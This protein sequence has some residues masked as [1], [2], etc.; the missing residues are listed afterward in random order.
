MTIHIWFFNLQYELN[1]QVPL[2]LNKYLPVLYSWHKHIK[3]I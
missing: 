2:K 1:M 3:G